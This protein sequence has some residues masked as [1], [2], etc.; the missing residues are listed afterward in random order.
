[1]IYDP[2]ANIISIELASGAISHARV[3]GNFIVHFSPA[4]KPTLLEIMNADKFEK[5]FLKN[6]KKVG[7]PNEVAT[8]I[9]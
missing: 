7:L 1:M 8:L 9:N 3:F 6:E 4:E 5:Q 2:E